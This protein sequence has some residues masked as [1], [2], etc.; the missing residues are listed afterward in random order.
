MEYF[1]LIVVFTTFQR[2]LLLLSS[3]HRHMNKNLYTL[4]PTENLWDI[5]DTKERDQG[6]INK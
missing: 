1:N 2:I 5:V 6:G 4:N 3:K